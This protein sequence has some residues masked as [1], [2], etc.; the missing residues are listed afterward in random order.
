MTQTLLT[1]RDLRLRAPEPSDLDTL[2]IWENDPE[3]WPCG[4]ATAPLSRH[5]LSEYIES[6]DANIFAAGQLRLVVEVEGRAAG[7]LDITDFNPRDHHARLGIFIAPE[8]RRRG[9][10]LRAL[11]L[12][13]AWAASSIGMHSLVALVAADNAPSRSLFAS[14]GFKT[15]GRMRSMLR[16]GRSY[17]DI[18][19]YQVLL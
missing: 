14:A 19:I 13:M 3:L 1:D 2:Y 15:C 12:A 4:N 11:R 5:R 8:Y 17:A 18:I 7:T 16:R 6:Y 10:A 9:Y